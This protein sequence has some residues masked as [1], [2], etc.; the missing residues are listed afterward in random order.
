MA[1]LTSKQFSLLEMVRLENRLADILGTKVDLASAKALKGD[2]RERATREAVPAFSVW[3]GT[4]ARP[5]LP[6]LLRPPVPDYRYRDS[7]PPDPARF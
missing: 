4:D 6:S 5:G 1:E 2:I 7:P 3:G